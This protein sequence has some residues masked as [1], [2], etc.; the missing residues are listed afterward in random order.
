MTVLTMPAPAVRVAMYAHDTPPTTNG[1]LRRYPLPVLPTLDWSWGYKWVSNEAT[2]EDVRVPLTLLD[3]LYPTGEE[4]FV[5]EAWMHRSL[6]VTLEVMIR[7]HLASRGWVVFGNVYVHWGLPGTPPLAPDVTAI[8][9]G[10]YPTEEEGSFYV[11]YHGP[12]PSFVIEVTSPNKPERD[13]DRKKWDYASFGVKEYLI[14]DGWSNTDEPWRLQGYRLGDQPFYDDLQADAEG[15]LTF[16]TVGLRFVGRERETVEV[17]D[18]ATGERLLPPE[19]WLHQ[20]EVATAARAQAE[21]RAEDEAAARTQAEARAEDEA[22]ARAQAEARAEDEAARATTE[23]KARAETESKLAEAL[24]R[25]RT[26]ESR[27]GN[28]TQA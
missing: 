20:A 4:I 14:I 3:L 19:E 11:G 10:D 16:A 25:L 12:V 2:G 26:L 1:R 7:A 24:A 22:A 23:A 27:S 17:Y 13:L 15:G 8:P 21:A 18:V 6:S 5:A 28:P 9:E